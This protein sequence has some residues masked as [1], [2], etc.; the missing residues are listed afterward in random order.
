MRFKE[1]S[2]TGE[3]DTSRFFKQL[4]CK[5]MV[6]TLRTAL[7]RACSPVRVYELG[8]YGHSKA[9]TRQ[10][11]VTVFPAHPCI[12]KHFVCLGQFRPLLCERQKRWLLVACIGHVCD[13]FFLQLALNEKRFGRSG[14]LKGW[15]LPCC[16]MSLRDW[17]KK[18]ARRSEQLVVADQ[19]KR[20]MAWNQKDTSA[21]I[22]Q[23]GKCVQCCRCVF[24]L[25]L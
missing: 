6:V 16:V 8:K 7:L 17:L 18:H 4:S 5:F 2:Q 13:T 20:Y 3:S 12:Q 25:E 11:A 23:F 22:W 15:Q 9:V 10:D 24:F 1:S 14:N 21:L 19:K